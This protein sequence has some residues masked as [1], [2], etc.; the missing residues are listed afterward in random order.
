ML[1]IPFH[2]IRKRAIVKYVFSNGKLLAETTPT[3]NK[4]CGIDIKNVNEKLSEKN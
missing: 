2:A 3:K 4:I 1:K